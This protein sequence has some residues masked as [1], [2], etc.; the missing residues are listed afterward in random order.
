M[1]TRRDFPDH[2]LACIANTLR[3]AFRYWIDDGSDTAFHEGL[4]FIHNVVL[5]FETSCPESLVPYDQFKKNATKTGASGFAD[6][7]R[8]ALKEE[9]LKFWRP[10]VTHGTSP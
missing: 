2:A 9:D 1:S 10:I 3:S 6:L 7:L 4:G 8:K 5:A